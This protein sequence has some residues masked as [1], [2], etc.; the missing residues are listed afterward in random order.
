M[1]K[2]KN[3]TMKACQGQIWWVDFDAYNNTAFQKKRPA[4]IVSSEEYHMRYGEYQVMVLTHSELYENEPAAIPIRTPDGKMSSILCWKTTVVQ[5]EELLAYY[6]CVPSYVMDNVFEAMNTVRNKKI[7]SESL[8][9]P[10][11]GGHGVNI[12]NI[13]G[14]DTYFDT[15]NNQ[16]RVVATFEVPVEVS[17]EDLVESSIP[18]KSSSPRLLKPTEYE[19]NADLFTAWSMLEKALNNR[20]GTIDEVAEEFGITVQK[21]YYF[22]RAATEMLSNTSYAKYMSTYS[23]R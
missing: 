1:E 8:D 6:G 22:R 2:M 19:S 7:D 10:T 12:K 11:Y 4:L 17:I 14:G 16:Q 21:M 3:I 15:G 9:K 5:E 18:P 20:T 23:N 13:R